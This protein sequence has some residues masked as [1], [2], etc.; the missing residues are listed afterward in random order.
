MPLMSVRT[1]A[2]QRAEPAGAGPQTDT[3][4]P[5]EGHNPSCAAVGCNDRAAEAPEPLA[6]DPP[7]SDPVVP[8]HA[9]RA[10]TRVSE[11]RVEIRMVYKAPFAAGNATIVAI[12]PARKVA[13]SAGC[14]DAEGALAQSLPVSI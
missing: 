3:A 9:V 5:A 7:G 14:G 6:P 13:D 4:G 10:V 1:K 11:S 8:L 2:K 12:F